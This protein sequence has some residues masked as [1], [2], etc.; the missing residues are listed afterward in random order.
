M[1][2]ATTSNFGFT[3]VELMV[4]VSIMV[5]L[6]SVLVINLAG[7]RQG[8]DIRIAQTQLVSNLRQA[9]SFTLS[10]RTLPNGQT[11]QYYLIKFDLN[12]P[13]Q[14]TLQALSNVSSSPQLQDIQTISLPPN[15]QLSATNPVSISRSLNPTTQTVHSSPPCAL[16]SFAAPF[17]KIIF[18]DG[19]SAS[20]PLQLSDD[21]YAKIINFQA[22][23]ACDGFNGNPP[24]PAICSASTDSL[25][26]ITLSAKDPSIPVKTVTING[27]TGAVTFN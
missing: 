25:M 6:T 2:L 16:V 20:S 5:I 26:T 19:C 9:Q 21:Y 14:Y 13:T 18:N 1:K 27:I 22:N 11:V 15:I 3:L 12:K 7:Q 10:S 24:N 8:R 4:V 23:V 17:G